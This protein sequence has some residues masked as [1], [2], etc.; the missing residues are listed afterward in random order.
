[1]KRSEKRFSYRKF[2]RMAGSSSPNFLQLIRDRV[3]N[4]RPKGIEALAKSLGLSV[5]EKAY[6]ET[7]VAFDHAKTHAQKDK[8]FRQILHTREYANIK[9]LEK[10]QYEFFSHWYI[11]VIRELVTSPLYPDNP[12]WICDHIEPAVSE[13][14]VRKA[15]ELL[16]SLGLIRRNSKTR[17]WEQ[18]ASVIS[19]PSEVLSVAV[20]KYH[21]DVIALGRDSIERFDPGERDIRSITM[22]ASEQGYRELKKRFEAF[23]KEILSFSE[24]QQCREDVYQVNM[25]FFPLTKKKRKKKQ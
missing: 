5:K 9:Q 16:A 19:T 18:T 10:N 8:F 7:I 14:K 12:S 2:A 17:Q 4:I 24:T 11:P 15:I 1:L 6:L 13:A 25:Q 3:L 22:G 21:R 20:T 23:W